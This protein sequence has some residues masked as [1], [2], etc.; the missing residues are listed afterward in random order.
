MDLATTTAQRTELA[1]HVTTGFVLGVEMLAMDAEDLR[2][3][4]GAAERANPALEVEPRTVAPCCAGGGRARCAGT[5]RA[6][7]QT[8]RRGARAASRGARP[9]AA[10]RAGPAGRVADAR[11]RRPSTSPH[12]AR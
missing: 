12:P 11:Q 2:E 9:G 6:A 3:H 8:V 7:A 1:F 10:R 5:G 4:L